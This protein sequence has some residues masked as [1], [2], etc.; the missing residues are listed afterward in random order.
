MKRM[1]KGVHL[2]ILSQEERT[3][4]YNNVKNLLKAMQRAQL[5]MNLDIGISFSV[6]TDLRSNKQ[7]AIHPSTI[8][9]LADYLLV[10]SDYL[11]QTH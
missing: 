3:N 11:L 6:C 5:D 10:T 2:V 8:N 1:H 9:A 7:R 4:L